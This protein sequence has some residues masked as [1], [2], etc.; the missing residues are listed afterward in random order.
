MTDP[1]NWL[2]W[3]RHSAP[4]INAHRG[5][6][7]V[8][9]LGGEVLE[10]PNLTHIIHD[11][12]LLAS[13][14]TRLVLVFGARPQIER[15]LEE[16]GAETHLHENGLR[17]TPEAHLPLVMEAVGRLRASLERRLSMGLINSPMHGARMRVVSGNLITAKPLGVLDGT[18]LG[19]TGRVRRVDSDGL[20][21][22]LDGGNIVILPPLGYSPTGDVFNLA[23]ED[24]ASQTAAALRAEKLIMFASSVGIMD[25][26]GALIRELRVRE[27][28]GLLNGADL[29]PAQA[30]ALQAACDACS[31]GVRRAHIISYEDEGALLEELFTRDGSGTLVTDD[32]YEEVRPARAEDIGGIQELIQPLE[33]AGVLV[34][35]PRELL[36]TEVDR[37][38]VDE[39]DGTI[40]G[41][42]ALY[43]YAEEG[44]GELACFAVSGQY[45]RFGRG[46]QVLAMIERVARAQGLERLFVLTTQ[47]EHW[48]RER[49][50]EP[51]QVAELPAARQAQYNRQRNSKIF[52]KPL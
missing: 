44:I 5:R 46:D 7:L 16:A 38:V 14:G 39:R 25:E 9:T 11:I 22:L 3:F 1:H 4:Y 37:F 50:F 27:A 29:S 30:E 20:E 26:A 17:V 21:A 12:T 48:F 18:D 32:P 6:T 43:P 8:L 51:A 40:I 13:L 23:Y 41:C 47:A 52:I 10:H 34:R 24:V 15:R 19:Y 35:R 2:Y 33:A 49:G 31:R 36:E 28:R 45:R 42:A